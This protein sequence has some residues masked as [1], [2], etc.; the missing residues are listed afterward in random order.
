VSTDQQTTDNQLLELRA[1]AERQGWTTVE[2]V[3][4]A[5]SGS[6]ES[7][8]ALDR[9]MAD[10]RRRRVDVVLVWR[11]DRFGRSLRHIVTA[12]DD[13]HAR[14]VSFVSLGEGIDLGTPTGK[15]QLHILAALAEFER[16]RIR[17]RVRA[18]LARVRAAGGR[19]GRPPVHL[20][21][22][23]VGLTV[24]AA[25]AAW[26]VSK[27]TAARRLAAGHV[28]SDGTNPASAPVGFASEG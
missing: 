5:I 23:P 16:E 10:A 2:Y 14:G 6:K 26:G 20:A 22:L 1:Y 27:S 28:P 9:L 25:A 15:L 7:R 17:E 18:G 3:D 19:L 8:P 12:L 11:L 24:R 13:L 4:S 21:T